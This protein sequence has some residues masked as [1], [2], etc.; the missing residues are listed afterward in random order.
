MLLVAVWSA[1]ILSFTLGPVSYH[2]TIRPETWLFILACIAAFAIGGAL[3]RWPAVP[4]DREPPSAR[5]ERRVAS[6]VM[7]LAAIGILGAIGLIVER[8][9][10]SGVDYSAGFTAA[11]L[12]RSE[13]VDAALADATHR[14]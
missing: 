14:T 8:L 2:D 4:F 10:L 11:R 9:F 6:V 5:Y 12:A 7:L 3:G 13:E 1:T